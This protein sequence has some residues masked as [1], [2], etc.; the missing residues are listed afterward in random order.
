[1]KTFMTASL[2][3]KLNEIPIAERDKVLD[4]MVE[5]LNCI[6]GYRKEPSMVFAG[7]FTTGELKDEGRS[8]CL[9]SK[10]T[11]WLC[12][13]DYPEDYSDKEIAGKAV[14]TYMLPGDY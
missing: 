9:N 3:A 4:T 5:A 10:L 2:K 11:F 13:D 1:M 14:Y 8:I 7:P 6:G 12:R